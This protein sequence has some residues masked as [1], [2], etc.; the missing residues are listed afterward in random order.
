MA[1]NNSSLTSQDINA[2]LSNITRALISKLEIF[3]VI[4]S[5]NNYLMTSTQSDSLSGHVCFAETQTQGKGRRGRQWISPQGQNIYG[6]F[7]WRFENTQALNGL[8]L[9]IGVGVIRALNKFGISNVSLKWPNDIYSADKKLGGILIEVTTHSNGSV[10]AVIG[11]GLNINLPKNIEQITQP[12]TDLNEIAPNV[13]ISRNQFVAQLLNE[14]LPIT[15]TFE[16]QGF[17]A[18]LDEW[19]EHD[20][21]CGKLADLFVGTQKHTGIVQGIDE[22]GL[23]KLQ[24][25]DGTIQTFASGEVSFSA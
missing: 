10:G 4:D 23:L 1:D 9:A 11:L 24:L 7:L 13:E 6:S 14:L 17:S 3:P 20:C 25:E 19:R 21:L 5:T 16:K 2:H 15:A 22:N 12:Y 18:Y 8:S